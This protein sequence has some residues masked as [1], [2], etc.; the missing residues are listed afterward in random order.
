MAQLV[1]G[2]CRSQVVDVFGDIAGI[3]FSPMT[4]TFFMAIT[5]EDYSSLLTLSRRRNWGSMHARNLS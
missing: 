1:F 5:L 3:G 2:I 4:D